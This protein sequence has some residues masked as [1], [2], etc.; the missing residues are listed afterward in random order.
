[1]GGRA[2]KPAAPVRG[3]V[4]VV[5]LPKGHALGTLDLPLAATVKDA[6]TLLRE[7][8][9]EALA[10]GTSTL[11]ENFIHVDHLTRVGALFPEMTVGELW[12]DYPHG[13][14]HFNVWLTVEEVDRIRQDFHDYPRTAH[15]VL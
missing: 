7:V 12:V 6:M 11:K 15:F 1:M 9:P 5:S 3:P 8:C 13:D 2:T 10:V 14:P 4:F